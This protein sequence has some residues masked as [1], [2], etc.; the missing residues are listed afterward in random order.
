MKLITRQIG[1]FFL[2]VVILFSVGACKKDGSIT[3]NHGKP[4]ENSVEYAPANIL[5]K[6][7]VLYNSKMQWTAK[8]SG[9]NAN[10]TCSVQV[11]PGYTLLTTPTYS[12]TKRN[13]NDADFNLN[14]SERLKIGSSIS[15]L[16]LTYPVY[17][18][19]T[20]ETG[21]NYTG[22]ENCVTTDNVSFSTRTSTRS[23]SGTF[24]LY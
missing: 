10:G 1:I 8:P 12:Y 21:G 9:F 13:K 2:L 11:F 4:P 16:K 14:Y 17:L 20:S 18:T 23:I 5:E 22:S 7:L 19:F 24:T 3:G 15:D 6:S